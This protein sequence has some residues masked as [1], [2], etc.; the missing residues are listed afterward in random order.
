MDN[1]DYKA[2]IYNNPLLQENEGEEL[3]DDFEDFGSELATALKS[4]LGKHEK[5][6]NEAAGLVGI[7]GWVLL[8]NTVANMIAKFAKKLSAKYNWGKGE[9]AA[10][11]IID[12]S[13]KIETGFE[14]PIKTVLSF[15]I[16]DEKKLQAITDILYAIVIFSMA[17]SAGGE[18]VKYIKK[19]GYLKGTIYGLKAAIKGVEVNQLLKRAVEDMLS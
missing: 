14:A 7:L 9:E 17:G 6:L 3:V 5:E 19:A 15:F 18:A 2:Y 13:H 11:K 12:I 4:E 16:K 8:S 1:F 10:K